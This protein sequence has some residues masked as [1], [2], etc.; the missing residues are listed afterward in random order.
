M[1]EERIFRVVVR[2]PAGRAPGAITMLGV[3]LNRVHGHTRQGICK[4]CVQSEDNPPVFLEHVTSQNG[5]VVDRIPC[6]V[7]LLDYATEIAATPGVQDIRA[8]IRRTP[9][10]FGN[11]RPFEIPIVGYEVAVFP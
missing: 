9:P 1:K 7:L 3:L 2:L 5:K 10:P 4:R 8:D 6:V 11:K